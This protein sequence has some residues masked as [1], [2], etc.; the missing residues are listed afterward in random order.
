MQNILSTILFSI[1]PQLLDVLISS[2]YLAQVMMAQDMS[3]LAV[4][5]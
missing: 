2:T 3:K 5:L 1:G 4:S